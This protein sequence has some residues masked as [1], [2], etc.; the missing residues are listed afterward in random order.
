MKS[1]G[2]NKIMRSITLLVTALALLAGCT[3]PA[4]ISKP[5][6][7]ETREQALSGLWKGKNKESPNQAKEDTGSQFLTDRLGGYSLRL[8]PNGQFLADW[9]GLIK[10]GTWKIDTGTIQLTN[11]RVFGK[12]REQSMA[13]NKD[14]AK[15]INDLKLFDADKVL[16][17][18]PGDKTLTLKAKNKGD[19]TVVFK[20]DSD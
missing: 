13:E 2:I 15:Q 12:N 14:Q 3:Q 11:V 20:H 1:T 6:V 5:T 17:L 19:E 7:P 16:E 18:A 4:P 10:E 9:R 8:M